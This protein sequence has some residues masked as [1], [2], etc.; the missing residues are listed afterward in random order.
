MDSLE[1]A[2]QGKPRILAIHQKEISKQAS[3]K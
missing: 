1:I 3:M 2:T